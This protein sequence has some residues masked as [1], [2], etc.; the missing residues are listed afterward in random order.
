MK[1]ENIKDKKEM[2]EQ[3]KKYIYII[4]QLLLFHPP[5]AHLMLL[6]VTI[7]SNNTSVSRSARSEILNAVLFKTEVVWDVTMWPFETSITM[8][9]L[10]CCN[11]P[12]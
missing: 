2:T 8:Y 12:E 5:N 10:T 9:Q 7:H 4:A 11:I 1:Q 6:S 3:F